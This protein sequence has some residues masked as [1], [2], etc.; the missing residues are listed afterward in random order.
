MSPDEQLAEANR[1]W[2]SLLRT[3]KIVQRSYF[4]LAILSII[5]G[6]A[7]A[8]YFRNGE[9]IL[10]S[11]HGYHSG[12]LI[13]VGLM[14]VVAL[15]FWIM[16]LHDAKLWSY[17]PKLAMECTNAGLQVLA[18]K[19]RLVYRPPSGT[20]GYG[21]LNGTIDGVDFWYGPTELPISR[22]WDWMWNLSFN[23]KSS[24]SSLGILRLPFAG[25][26]DN[27]F[28]YISKKSR[29]STTSPKFDQSFSIHS[30]NDTT[31][32]PQVLE[33]CLKLSNNFMLL[34]MFGDKCRFIFSRLSSAEDLTRALKIFR[35]ISA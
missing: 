22:Y 17:R 32:P 24:N 4:A 9:I 28:D 19:M 34:E 23:P 7:G 11:I 3:T 35:E 30:D 18:E 2:Q 26:P 31:L 14:L 15:E 21:I 5:A 20:K 6:L 13:V 10:G 1:K 25:G 27:P 16:Y 33:E 12:V 29:I 8:W